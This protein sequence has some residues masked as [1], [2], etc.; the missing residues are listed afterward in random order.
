M[1]VPAGDV[2]SDSRSDHLAFSSSIVCEEASGFPE[3]HKIDVW[4]FLYL[5]CLNSCWTDRRITGF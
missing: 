5:S 1:G 3:Q 4:F 2:V